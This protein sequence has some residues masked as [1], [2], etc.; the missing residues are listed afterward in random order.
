MSDRFEKLFSLP[1]NLYSEELPII[2]TAGSLLKDKETGKIIVQLKYHSVSPILIIAL[3]VGISAYDVLGK[4]I[5]GIDEYQY[6][7]LYVT[8]GQ[9]FG[10]NKAIIMPNTVTRSINIRTITAILSNG[11]TYSVTMP[12]HTLPK[13]ADIHTV[14]NNDQLVKQYQLEIGR[15]PVYAPQKINNLWCCTCGEWNSID[16]CDNC[17]ANKE[18][19]FNALN[20][21]TLREK[22]N[23][24]IDAEEAA[25]LAHE[26]MLKTRIKKFLNKYSPL[27]FVSILIL[28]L[29]CSIIWTNN[30]PKIIESINGYSHQTAS[31]NQSCKFCEEKATHKI[32]N[33]TDSIYTDRYYCNECWEE[34]GESY[35]K[36]LTK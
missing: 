6:L 13:S 24:R 30:K 23:D 36:Q 22:A 12:S 31:Y 35:F 16:C 29:I 32:H 1:E 20:A 4:E 2:I 21:E 7:D 11:T 19:I 3:K 25:Q 10:S 33:T 26:R 14:L 8:H 15:T 18:D 17:D 5:E 27:F 34:H 28:C 9:D